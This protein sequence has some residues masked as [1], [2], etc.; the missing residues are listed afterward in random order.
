MKNLN[1]D[2]K[3]E[4]LR[5]K[6]SKGEKLTGEDIL[7]LTFLPLMRSK[8]NKSDVTIES[9]ELAEEYQKVT[10]NFSV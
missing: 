4:Y 9:I 1:G 6:I 5:E 7:T 2:E 3:L 8:K 10:K